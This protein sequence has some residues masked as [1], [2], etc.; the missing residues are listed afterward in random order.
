MRE[1]DRRRCLAGDRAAAEGDDLYLTEIDVALARDKR[2]TAHNDIVGD[3]RPEF[4]QE[5]CRGT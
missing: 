3:R 2:L 1:P 5:I 4:Y